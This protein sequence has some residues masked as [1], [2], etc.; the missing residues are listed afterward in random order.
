[1]KPCSALLSAIALV[2][3]TRPMT[4]QDAIKPE[5]LDPAAVYEA[6]VFKNPGGG[7][8][9]YR[10]LKPLDYDPAKKYP[11]VL[12]LH[13][14][15][16]RGDDNKAQLVHGCRDLAAEGLRRR[17]PAFVVAPQC[18]EEQKWVEVPWDRRTHSMPADPSPSMK[19][20]FDLLDSLQAEFSIDEAR[21]YGV[22]LSMGGY[23]VW[24]TLQRKPEL[25]AAAI[26]VCGGGDPEHAATFKSTPVWAFHGADDALVV[27]ERSRTMVAAL[28]A[29]GG[30]PV[31]TE[32]EGVGHDSWSATFANRAVWDW[33]FAQRRE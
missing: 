22:G 13:G 6:R 9:N 17:Y 33:L 15:G 18:P 28:T 1:M 11:V 29:A 10:L 32:Y 3:A 30:H 19:H 2:L 8:L 21:L 23:G 31:Y 5:A 14:A 16:E 25:L 4:A 12:L 27:P 26:P 7:S 20:V 24:D